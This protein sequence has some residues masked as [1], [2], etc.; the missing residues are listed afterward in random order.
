[1]TVK[2]VALD[3]NTR[4]RHYST[5]KDIIAI[6]FKCCETFY[7]CY[8]CHEQLADHSPEVWDKSERDVPAVLC[9]SCRHVLTIQEYM[10]SI[11]FCPKCH[12]AFNPGCKTH[13]HLYFSS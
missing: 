10:D 8:E 6:K 1:M 7:A 12:S 11:N 2:G 5:D 3:A 9:G 4:C 13:Y